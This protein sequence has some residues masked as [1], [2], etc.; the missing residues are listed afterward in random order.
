VVY[1]LMSDFEVARAGSG[2]TYLS[3]S[4]ASLG[5]DVKEESIA[6]E[7]KSSRGVR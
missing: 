7:R 5:G 2:R 3:L 4:L 1:K 6:A